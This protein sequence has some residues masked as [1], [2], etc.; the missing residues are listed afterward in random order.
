MTH[1]SYG[2][3]I[4]PP[5]PAAVSVRTDNS[6]GFP[7]D[8]IEVQVQSSHTDFPDGMTL[9]LV[10]EL[11]TIASTTQIRDGRAHV[12]IPADAPFGDYTLRVRWRTWSLDSVPFEVSE[13]RVAL[14]TRNLLQASV[15]QAEAFDAVRARELDLTNTCIKRAS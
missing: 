4:D 12:L 7:G 2:S 3:N 14:Q 15:K 1:F 9:E 5:P 8:S 10:D 13:K 6:I 11:G